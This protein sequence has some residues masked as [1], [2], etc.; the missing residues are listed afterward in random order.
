MY[1]RYWQLNRKPFDDAP[2][3]DSFVSCRS[4]QGCLLKL[5][6]LV[7]H[8]KGVGLVA[9]E[10]G[11]GKTYLTRVL[12]SELERDRSGPVVRMLMPR[13]SPG[14][15]LAYLA[16]R[17]GAVAEPAPG[18]DVPPDHLILQRL[19]QKLLEL[20]AQGA[21]PLVIIDDAHALEQVHLDMVTLLLN[22]RDA[23]TGIPSILL[24]GRTELLGQV[25]LSPGLSQRIVIRA[26]VEPLDERETAQYISGRMHSAGG[27][28][29]EFQPA[30]LR[31]V[32]QLTQGV[33]RRINHLC[34]L[35]LLVGF[36]DQLRTVSSLEIDAAAEELF[37]VTVPA[38]AAA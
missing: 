16:G 30:A 3:G 11:V 14:G 32:W 38:A 24:V 35:A 6:Y 5:R 34:D 20:S 29:R 13:L 12:A 7:E 21:R 15:M 26:A 33:P 27:S 28:G 10:H 37:S 36:A 1:E 18:D 19:E 25:E 8:H 4:A 23:G 2:G 17:L 9:G 22:L 31:R